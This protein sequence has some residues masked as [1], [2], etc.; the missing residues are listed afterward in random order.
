M[1]PQD[2]RLAQ[3]SSSSGAYEINYYNRC[4]INIY[5]SSI[6]LAQLKTLDP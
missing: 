2:Y 5:G 4:G 3:F 6:A 1:R